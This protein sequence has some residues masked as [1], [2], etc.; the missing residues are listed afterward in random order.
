MAR[1]TTDASIVAL[2]DKC[3]LKAVNVGHCKKITDVGVCHLANVCVGLTVLD[4]TYCKNLTAHA[5]HYVLARCRMIRRLVL[6][7]CTSITNGTVACLHPFC[8][9]E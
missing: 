1:N 8:V 7:R 4:L 9:C 6:A 3:K 2:S 5:L